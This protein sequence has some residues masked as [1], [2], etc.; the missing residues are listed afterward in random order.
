MKSN[1]AGIL[2]EIELELQESDQLKLA[3]DF[4]LDAPERMW[5]I[6]Q[7]LLIDEQRQTNELLK[8][9]M[10]GTRAV[11]LMQAKYLDQMENIG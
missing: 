2:Q 5:L 3:K 7:T 4:A 1:I 10:E 9:L 8:G 6:A 11:L